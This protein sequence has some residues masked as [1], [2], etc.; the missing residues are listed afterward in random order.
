M[1]QNEVYGYLGRGIAEDFMRAGKLK[2]RVERKGSRGRGLKIYA[3]QDVLE[4]EDQ[5]LNGNYP[6]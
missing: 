6:T 3:T 2:P 4:C 5:L 1:T